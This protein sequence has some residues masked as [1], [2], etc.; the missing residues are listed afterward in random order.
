[1]E[2][3]ESQSEELFDKEVR[4]EVEENMPSKEEFG[5]KD[6]VKNESKNLMKEEFLDIF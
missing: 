3:F 5:P 6:E 2:V 4:K 1:M